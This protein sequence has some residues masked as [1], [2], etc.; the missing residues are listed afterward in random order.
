MKRKPLRALVPDAGK[1]FQFVD[2]VSHRLGKLR[3]F[4]EI[5]SG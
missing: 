5:F 2:Q 4:R 1:F 3:H